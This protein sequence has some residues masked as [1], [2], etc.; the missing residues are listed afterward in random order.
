MKNKLTMKEMVRA[1][2]FKATKGKRTAQNYPD[3]MYLIDVIP[4][5]FYRWYIEK[6]WTDVVEGRI[7][8]WVAM[9]NIASNLEERFDDKGRRCA[10]II[11]NLLY[12]RN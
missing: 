2:I 4:T 3:G 6:V 10:R 7:S 5:C 1:I 8:A 11:H 9:L 12:N